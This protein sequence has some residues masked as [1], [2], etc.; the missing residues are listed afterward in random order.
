MLATQSGHSEK[1]EIKPGIYDLSNEQYHSPI[2]ISR[3]AIMEFKKS[4]FHYWHKYINPDYV[5]K[6]STPAQQF[7]SAVHTYILEPKKFSEEYFVAET[8]PHH[9]NSTLGKEFKAQQILKAGSK[10]VLSA[11]DFVEIKAMRASVYNNQKCKGV[12]TQA[13]YEKSIFWI[14]KDTGLLCKARPDIW[15]DK[16][17]VDLKTAATAQ[18]RQY[19]NAFFEY[20]YHIQN[21]MI[22]EGIRENTG[23]TIT[24]FLNLVIEKDEPYAPAT[25][26]IKELVIELGLQEFKH[27]LKE[28]KNCMETNVWPSYESKTIIVPHYLRGDL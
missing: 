9:G 6:P 4:P 24:H 23:Q 1:K 22:Q 12:L 19:T 11:E 18:M 28:I 13:R 27:Y 20:G 21:A 14:D 15:H 26:P 3:S 2:G 16:F 7:G 8:N 25:Y 5:K 10:I 17:I